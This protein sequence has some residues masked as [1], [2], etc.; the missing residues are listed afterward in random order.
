MHLILV[1]LDKIWLLLIGFWCIGVF[2][3]ILQECLEWIFMCVSYIYEWCNVKKEILPPRPI[4]IRN[5]YPDTTISIV[6]SECRTAGIQECIH[7]QH[8]MPPWLSSEQR[9][10]VRDLYDIYSPHSD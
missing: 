4:E 1:M 7:T 9:Q 8:I 3:S 5:V 6:C 2:F 10:K